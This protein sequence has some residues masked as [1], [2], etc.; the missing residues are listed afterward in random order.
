M[1]I[2]PDSY[3]RENWNQAYPLWLLEKEWFEREATNHFKIVDRLVWTLL[4][5]GAMYQ[6][7]FDLKRASSKEENH[8]YV[9]TDKNLEDCLRE[10][11]ANLSREGLTQREIAQETGLG[12]GT[13]NRKLKEIKEHSD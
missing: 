7:A 5:L 9:W 6:L 10:K 13:I 11:I 1:Q 4:R 12:L 2:P 3:F 8:R